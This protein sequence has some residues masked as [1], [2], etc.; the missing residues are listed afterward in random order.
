MLNKIKNF[1]KNYDI[2]WKFLI[3]GKYLGVRLYPAYFNLRGLKSILF[4]IF[5]NLIINEKIK[6]K[7]KQFLKEIYEIIELKGNQKA[8]F[9]ISSP[10]SG[11]NFIRYLLSS[12]FEIKFNTGN[13]IPKFDNQTKISCGLLMFS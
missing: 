11:G 8:N 10:S 5:F 13:G 6:K 7:K 1:L 9:L 4:K 12:Y 3:I 2:R